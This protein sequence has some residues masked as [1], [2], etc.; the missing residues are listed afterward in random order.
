M[1]DD[2]QLTLH[3]RPVIA[4]V[5]GAQGRNLLESGACGNVDL[6]DVDPHPENLD[7]VFRPWLWCMIVAEGRVVDVAQPGCP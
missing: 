2:S 1:R 3:S 6:I 5:F 7:P 4:P